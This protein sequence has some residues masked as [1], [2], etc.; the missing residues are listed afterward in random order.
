MLADQVLPG[1][2]GY[3]AA[4]LYN[5]NNVT[6]EASPV[7]TSYEVE[8]AQQLARMVGYATEKSWGHVT[9]GGTVANFEA[10]RVARNLKY[11]PLAVKDAH[12]AARQRG[13]LGPEDDLEILLPDGR[14]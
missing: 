1:I 2:V 11:F 12:L 4:M 10:L 6:R 5:P 14:A 7:T 8:V 3:F 9:S 13:S